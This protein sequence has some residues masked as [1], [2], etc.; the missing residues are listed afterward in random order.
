MAHLLG[1]RVQGY[2]A[3]PNEAVVP[4]KRDS[5]GRMARCDHYGFGKL[6]LHPFP[7]G[8]FFDHF[9]GYI[10][11]IP[12]VLHRQICRVLAVLDRYLS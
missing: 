3:W 10:I 1:R 5:G 8:P 7:F 2:E 12:Q 11:S 4:V 9:P 6:V